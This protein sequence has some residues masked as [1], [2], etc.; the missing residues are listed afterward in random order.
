MTASADSPLTV[1]EGGVR[2]RLYDQPVVYALVARGYEADTVLATVHEREGM[3]V[4]VSQEEADDDGLVY[5]FV[6]AWITLE[7]RTDLEAIG[8]T[9]A[10]SRALADAGI[11]CNVVAG[12]HHDHVVV[13]WDVRHDALEVLER[14]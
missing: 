13:P 4:V 5:E 3:T 12:F 7:A 6:G 1:P 11:A 10:L 2:P 14:L 8:L 9:A